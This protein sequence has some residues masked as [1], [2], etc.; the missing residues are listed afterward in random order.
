LPALRGILL[1]AG[2]QVRGVFTGKEQ[3]MRLW[4]CEPRGV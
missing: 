2:W 4:L 3:P 1:A